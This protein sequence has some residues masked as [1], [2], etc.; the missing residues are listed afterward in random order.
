MPGKVQINTQ[1]TCNISGVTDGRVTSLGSHTDQ[2]FL[3]ENNKIAQEFQIVSA[4]FPIPTAGILGKDFIWKNKCTVC[5]SSN[6]LTV[7]T[8]NKSFIIPMS[9]IFENEIWIPPRSEIIRQIKIDCDEDVVITNKM[10]QPNVFVSNS[11]SSKHHAF[12]RLLNV[13]T[14]MERIDVRDI[15]FEPISN[16]DAVTV[17]S[18]T[19]K[20]FNSISTE[21]VPLSIKN[22]FFKL[23]ADYDDIFYL[24]GDHLA[25]NNFYEQEISPIDNNPIYKKNYRIPEAQKAEVNAQISKM[26]EDGIIEPSTS[27]YNNPIFLVPKKSSG[28]AKWRLVV[29]FRELNKVILP[30]RFPLPRIEDILDALGRA[31]FFSTLDL[32]S[33]FHQV[34][35]EKNSRKYTAFST[36]TNHFQFTRLPFGLSISP[37][38]FQRMM[39]IALSGLPPEV[40]FLYI[41]DIIVIGGS[42][43]HH[44]KNLQKVFD[45][46]RK[47]NL[48]LN[49][50]K[51]C[52]FR[53]EVTFLGHLLTDKG[54][55]PD[56]TKIS[57]VKTMPEPIDASEVKRFV[58]FVNFYR[59]FIK[60]FS[61]IATPLHHLTKKNVPFIWSEGCR[62]AFLKLKNALANPPILKYPE[63]S[64]DFIL[65]TDASDKGCGAKLAQLHDGV[66]MPIAYFSKAFKKGEL[67]RP[68]IE[69]EMMAIYFAINH[70]RPYLFGRKFLLKTDHKPLVHMW[71]MKDP[72]SK[73]VRM[74]L[75]LNE[76]DFDIVYIPG[77]DN[78][79][80]DALSRINFKNL[81]DHQVLA[82]TRSKTKQQRLE[83][84]F[85]PT[86][87]ELAIPNVY[88]ALIPS[89]VRNL[90][91]LRF[92]FSDVAITYEVRQKRRL[93][94]NGNV[95]KE[96]DKS[97]F[98]VL[99]SL[100][101][102]I[103]EKA[104]QNDI[105]KLYL[106]TKDEVFR[107]LSIMR[108]KDEASKSLNTLF[109]VLYSERQKLSDPQAIQEVL[110][111]LHDS[112]V[113]GHP[114]QQRLLKKIKRYYKWKG[115]KQDV[116]NYVKSCKQ[117]SLNKQSPYTKE[118]FVQTST[119]IQPFDL[120]SV[121]TVGPLPTTTTGNKYVVSLQCNFSKYVIYVPV[122]DKTAITI[123]KAIVNNLILV[124]GPINQILS[125]AGTDYVNQVLN[126]I[127]EVLKIKKSHGTAS[128]PQ[129]IGALERNHKTLNEYLRT[130]VPTGD[131]WD[132]WIPYY[133]YAYNT[134]P[135]LVHNYMP[136]ELI[137]GKKPRIPFDSKEIDIVYNYESY[138]KELKFKLQNAYLNV[139]DMLEKT[140]RKMINNQN[141]I[142]PLVVG[143]GDKVKLLNAQ[144]ENKLSPIYTGPYTVI[145][146]N[147]VNCTIEDINKKTSIVHKNRLALF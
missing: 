5:A 28:A 101:K 93:I 95:I 24:P 109:V 55:L 122:P 120:I 108:F 6:T 129:T 3:N 53:K 34:G 44:L 123:A 33:G 43:R 7:R 88:E 16:F 57:S 15:T 126:E 70:F 2:I 127:C 63:F 41:D 30:D 77:K 66:E 130:T 27:P 132:N 86:L 9:N 31:K 1:K 100:L 118:R 14:Q 11:I 74:R 79:E 111:T 17:S 140:K 106:D 36:P 37:N 20:L 65:I 102:Q 4:Q 135:N 115:L 90:P 68:P 138:A 40:A 146:V 38:A 76:Y 58:A 139:K 110:K 84:N 143:I 128:H 12:V 42:E 78:V 85:A 133:A 72:N 39:M 92:S 131:D 117:C 113:S 64:K 50:E 10:L 51:C 19:K 35:L 13:N 145:A 75:E 91:K 114:G 99:P 80:A 142:T 119:P 25:K 137:F 125:D 23:C 62:Q 48:K 59:R 147:G 61:V 136:F 124:Y 71:S 97:I 73:V 134:T 46:L 81:V 121:D 87:D 32:Q 103:E 104:Q 21:N 116:K 112:A 52:F 141:S 83:S 94:F 67:N 107:Y 56:E 49:P 29:D 54:I 96:Q 82:I 144:K 60:D 45:C 26:K 105:D 18:R 22:D 98:D 89:E 8:K 47:R 69:K